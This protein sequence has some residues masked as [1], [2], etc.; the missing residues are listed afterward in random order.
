ME[1]GQCLW[2]A[3]VSNKQPSAKIYEDSDFIA[4]LD[5]RP[6]NYGHVL[7]IP[8][9]HFQTVFEMPPALSEKLFS[10]CIKL[11]SKIIQAVPCE[12]LNMIYGIGQAA[13]QRVPHVLVHLIPR[14]SA[15]KVI[16]NWDSIEPK[17]EEFN[18]IFSALV[19]ALK[20]ET[21]VQP[22]EKPKPEPAPVPEQPK[23]EEVI[24]WVDRRVP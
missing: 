14:L 17:Q 21:I 2:C 23:K 8:K 6:A 1:Q 24:R 4:V 16:I 20:T 7:V 13:G 18:K 15:D 9:E 10:L 22:V 12:G 5:I 19:S 11:S 3:I